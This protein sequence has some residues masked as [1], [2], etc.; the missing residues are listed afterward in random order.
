MSILA[1]VDF[2]QNK[3]PGN[4]TANWGIKK[5]IECGWSKCCNMFCCAVE[6]VNFLHRSRMLIIPFLCF[7]SYF[8]RKGIFVNYFN[9]SNLFFDCY[10]YMKSVI[11]S[12]YDEQKSIV[13]GKYVLRRYISGECYMFDIN[14]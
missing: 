10:K 12:S 7:V 13:S 9:F 1:F 11:G 3:S 8:R 5:S 6:V 14:M 2:L 4:K